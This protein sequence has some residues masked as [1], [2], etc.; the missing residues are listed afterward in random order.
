MTLVLD[1]TKNGNAMLSKTMIDKERTGDVGSTVPWSLRGNNKTGNAT[2]AM[3]S[4]NGLRFKSLMVDTHDD[5][6]INEQIKKVLTATSFSLLIL[7]QELESDRRSVFCCLIQYSGL[8]LF[9]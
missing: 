5:K 3:S 4:P 8:T 2:K 1:K 6:K 9:Q 7:D